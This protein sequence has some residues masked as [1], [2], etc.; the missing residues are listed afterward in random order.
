MN[1]PA[2]SI[3]L[4][5]MRA[6]GHLDEA[7]VLIAKKD[8]PMG[9]IAAEL[10]ATAWEIDEAL[11]LALTPPAP[12]DRPPLPSPDLTIPE[13]KPRGRR[14]RGNWQTRQIDGKAHP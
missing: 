12:P 10:Q 6:R 2:E 8:K 1:E 9:V 14:R 11:R 4:A 13:P 3:L 7:H 5:M